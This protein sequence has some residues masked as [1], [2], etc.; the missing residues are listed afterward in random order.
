VPHCFCFYILCVQVLCVA[1]SAPALVPFSG[2][3]PLPV[4]L[5]FSLLKLTCSHS[6]TTQICSPEGR[7]DM[8]LDPIV[9]RRSST[10]PPDCRRS[11]T[12][13]CTCAVRCSSLSLFFR[14]I[15]WYEH[16]R[17]ASICTSTC[18]HAHFSFPHGHRWS[19]KVAARTTTLLLSARY[20]ITPSTPTRSSLSSPKHALFEAQAMQRD[21]SLVI[22]SAAVKV[23][24]R[25]HELLLPCVWVDLAIRRRH[26]NAAF[27]LDPVSLVPSEPLSRRAYNHRIQG[28]CHVVWPCVCACVHVFV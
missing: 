28:I 27:W 4:S 9:R 26:T 6:H 15:S 1:V 23:V 16:A 8:I 18:T 13:A 22:M 25:V 21:L 7:R 14:S 19:R 3:L 12:F 20:A 17:V 2:P 5:S 10:E 11:I 24:V